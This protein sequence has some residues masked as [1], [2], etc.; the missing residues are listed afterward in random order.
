MVMMHACLGPSRFGEKDAATS[1][2]LR[3]G[4]NM[5]LVS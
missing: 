5:L 3:T 2:L 4:A 1:W